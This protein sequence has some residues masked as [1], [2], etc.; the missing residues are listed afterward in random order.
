MKWHLG[1]REIQVKEENIR[2]MKASKS[3]LKIRFMY[4]V[5]GLGNSIIKE[6][7]FQTSDTQSKEAILIENDTFL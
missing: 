5:Q 4:N 6:I 2:T 7:G 3:N 1:G